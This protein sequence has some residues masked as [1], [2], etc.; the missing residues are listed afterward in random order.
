MSDIW[1][2]LDSQT[3]CT[4]W[5]FN[6][7]LGCIHF[8]YAVLLQ[9]GCE[10]ECSH[11]TREFVTASRI[12]NCIGFMFG[13]NKVTDRWRWDESSFCYVRQKS[14]FYIANEDWMPYLT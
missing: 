14:N 2:T 12:D 5:F 4:S 6:S 13:E 10:T 11:A 8:S 7:K 3:L 1:V 9:V